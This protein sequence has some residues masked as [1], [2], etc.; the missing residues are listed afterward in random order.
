MRVLL[1]GA[2]EGLILTI[3]SQDYIVHWPGSIPK[4]DS[5]R[6]VGTTVV[7]PYQG[8]SIC[9]AEAFTDV[10]NSSKNIETSVHNEAVHTQKVFMIRHP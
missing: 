2:Q 7:L 10:L 4:D 5:S 6:L 1:I 3:T 9:D 8:D